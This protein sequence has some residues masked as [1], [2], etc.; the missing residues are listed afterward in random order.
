MKDQEALGQAILSM[1]KYLP[2]TTAAERADKVEMNLL[3]DAKKSESM[4]TETVRTYRED[5]VR[6]ALAGVKSALTTLAKV[7][8]DVYEDVMRTLSQA[9]MQA[10]TDTYLVSQPVERADQRATIARLCGREA[11]HTEHEYKLGNE[12]YLCP[13]RAFI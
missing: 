7:F 3:P 13:G 4:V 8:P 10:G 9:D 11:G 2:R 1:K 12:V 6:E 5:R